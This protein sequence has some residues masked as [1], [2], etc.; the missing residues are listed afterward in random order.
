[1]SYLTTRTCSHTWVC[2]YKLAILTVFISWISSTATYFWGLCNTHAVHTIFLNYMQDCSQSYT[3]RT[4]LYTYMCLSVCLSRYILTIIPQMSL[5]S[6]LLMA[7]SIALN[8][9]LFR[10]WASSRLRSI[11]RPSNYRWVE[12]T[13]WVWLRMNAHTHTHTHTHTHAH[14]T[15]VKAPS[16]VLETQTPS[17]FNPLQKFCLSIK[18]SN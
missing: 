8:K 9:L 18:L 11:E 2:Q 13:M 4:G 12:N 5:D 17:F 16:L 1:M 14:Q 7:K 10:R 15:W 6:N 3:Y